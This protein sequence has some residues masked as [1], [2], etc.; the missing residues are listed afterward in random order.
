MDVTD[1]TSTRVYVYTDGWMDDDAP[2]FISPFFYRTTT[3][4]YCR[5]IIKTAIDCNNNNDN[6]NDDTTTRRTGRVEIAPTHPRAGW[7]RR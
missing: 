2:R 7:G 3:N 4:T 6:D 5:I 1:V